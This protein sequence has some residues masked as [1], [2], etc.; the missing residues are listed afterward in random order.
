MRGESVVGVY[1]D[2]DVAALH[3]TTVE[4]WGNGI[5]HVHHLDGPWWWLF[6]GRRYLMRRVREEYGYLDWGDEGEDT[7]PV[8]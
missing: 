6:M 8:P 4:V 2:H 5:P 3:F 1:R 7:A